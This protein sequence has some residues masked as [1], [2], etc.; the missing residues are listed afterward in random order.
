MMN[1]KRKEIM[2]S[3]T[4]YATAIVY[5]LAEHS[6]NKHIHRKK[7]KHNQTP[8]SYLEMLSKTAGKNK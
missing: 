3:L 8:Y 7:Y 2:P 1:L 6:E 5:S 4:A